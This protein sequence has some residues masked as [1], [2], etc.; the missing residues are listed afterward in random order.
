MAVDT[1]NKRYSL[2]GLLAI[3]DGV[4][5]VN[6]RLQLMGLYSGIVPES[7]LG[8]LL[9]LNWHSFSPTAKLTTQPSE[10]LSLKTGG[11]LWQR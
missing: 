2:I 7:A 4:L 5:I 6:D 8:E 3:P 10:K 9:A 1:A 11:L